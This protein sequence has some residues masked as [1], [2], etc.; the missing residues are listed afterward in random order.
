MRQTVLI[1]GA[2]SG[3][4]EEL[5]RLYAAQGRHLA[6][7]ARRTERLL[8]L[9]AELGARFGTRVE[10]RE[11]DVTNHQAVF[12]VFDDFARVLGRIDRFVVN[13]GV[14]GGHAV[15]TGQFEPNLRLV[16]TN[17]VAGLAQC[18]AAVRI[19]RKQGEGHLAVVSSM[20][21]MR[22]LPSHMTVYAATKAGIAHLAEGIRAD[23]AGTPIAVSTIFPGYIR[24]EINAH[25]GRLPF[26]VDQVTG[27]KALFRAIES[28]KATAWVPAWP[29]TI[30]GRVMRVVPAR[31]L[32]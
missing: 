32:V 3:L 31:F 25:K 13:A 7:C 11:L 27:A 24:T 18:E 5:A 21:A 22:G 17:F 1:T 15:G 19:L 14:N 12:D 20:S 6:L 4:G 10:V 9:Q 2:S 23:L 16:E 30:V 8:S 29:W 26:E 28:E